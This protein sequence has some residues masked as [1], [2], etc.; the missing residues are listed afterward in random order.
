M[1]KKILTV[2]CFAACSEAALEDFS[3]ITRSTSGPMNI[4]GQLDG[5]LHSTSQ[6]DARS[7]N[8]APAQ[9]MWFRDAA[10]IAFDR[11]TTEFGTAGS[12]ATDDN[13]D[14]PIASPLAAPE[15]DLFRDSASAYQALASSLDSPNPMAVGSS[16]VDQG[17][18]INSA[19][20]YKALASSLDNP[21]PDASTGS[22]IAGPTDDIGS[23]QYEEEMDTDLDSILAAYASGSASVPLNSDPASVA[24]ATGGRAAAAAAHPAYDWRATA[25][26]DPSTIHTGTSADMAAIPQPPVLPQ[27]P[28]RP[29][30]SVAQEV[31]EATKELSKKE[32]RRL[33]SRESSRKLR[34]NI[35]VYCDHLK[36]FIGTNLIVRSRYE[37][38]MNTP[39]RLRQLAE[40]EEEFK[41]LRERK[42]DSSISG[43]EYQKN[44][45]ALKAKKSRFV[46]NKIALRKLCL[47]LIEEGVI[48]A[49]ALDK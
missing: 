12:L 43:E 32:G 16:E 6:P 40:I 38:L 47:D 41:L 33:K 27:P 30:S 11:T 26:A 44:Y 8:I 17:I 18:F 3:S 2:I 31:R 19:L 1:Y 20:A 35:S 7:L 10:P 4:Q 23:T 49:L 5:S 28:V 37:A 46:G 22:L 36:Q 25:G 39:E 48:P 21:N 42:N 9:A 14:D 34:Q 13:L 29:L 15:G 45:N 24:L